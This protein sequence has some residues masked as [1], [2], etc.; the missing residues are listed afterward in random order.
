LSIAQALSAKA[1][2][3]RSVIPAQAGIQY[4]FPGFR[5]SPGSPGMTGCP[6]YPTQVKSFVSEQRSEAI[7]GFG[8]RL[9]REVCPGLVEGL[10]TNG[11]FSPFP[12][13]PP[14]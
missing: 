2:T 3:K 4:S 10:S 5:V 11:A 13:F 12:L 14:V 1:E 8:Q 6:E 7:P 9:L